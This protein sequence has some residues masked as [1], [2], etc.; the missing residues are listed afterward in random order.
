MSGQN[1]NLKFGTTHSARTIWL[2]E[3]V[4]HHMT[5]KSREKNEL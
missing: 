3:Q 2:A 1:W 4:S 5:F